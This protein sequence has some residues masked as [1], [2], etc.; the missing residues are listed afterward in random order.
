M[1]NEG[2]GIMRVKV[3]RVFQSPQAQ[4]LNVR[5]L[6]DLWESNEKSLFHG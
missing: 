3:G 4:V 1:W 5:D 6:L 2:F